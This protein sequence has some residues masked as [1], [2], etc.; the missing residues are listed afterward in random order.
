[1]S[2]SAKIA[3]CVNFNLKYDQSRSIQP[4]PIEKD[5]VVIMIVGAYFKMM[6]LDTHP[7][8]VVGLQVSFSA[9]LLTTFKVLLHPC[10]HFVPLKLLVLIL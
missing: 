1:M 5:T 8:A 2:F 9:T 3:R 7:G 6:F 4:D 10:R